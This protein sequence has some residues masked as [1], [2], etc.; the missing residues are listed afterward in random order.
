MNAKFTIAQ[1]AIK[2]LYVITHGSVI[3]RS[4]SEN[5]HYYM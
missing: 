5:C 4:G 2:V 1:L 3:F